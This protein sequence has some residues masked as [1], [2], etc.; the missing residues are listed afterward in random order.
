MSAKKQRYFD[1]ITKNG[2]GRKVCTGLAAA[3]LATALTAS[4][5]EAEAQDSVPFGEASIFVGYTWGAG[6]GVNW[7]IE[8]RAGADFRDQWAC[9]AEPAFSAAAV[10]RFSFVDLRPQFHVSGQAG[11][12]MSM[13]SWMGDV[14][15]GYRWGEDGGFS[16]PLGFELQVFVAQTYVRADPVLGNISTGGGLFLPPRDGELGCAVAGRALH[17]EVGHAALPGVE[18]LDEERLPNDMDPE[19]ARI[20]AAQWEQRAK[21]EWASVP[22]FL[23]LAEQLR[24]AGA[25]Q[26]LIAR[27]HHA[28]EDELRHAVAT[29][30]AAV[31]YSG[32]PINLGQVT[33]ATRAPARGRD[34]LVRLAAESWVDGCL[35]E[36]KAAAAAA[37]EARLAET[38]KLRELQTMIAVDEARHADLAWDVLAWT[39]R[40]GGDDVRHA[41]SAVR[42]ATPMESTGSDEGLDLGEHGLLPESTH[43]RIGAELQSRA[44][45]R[46]DALI[47]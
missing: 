10:A 29:A 14:G 25:P 38:P 9:T 26:R 44:L 17:D 5:A 4:P 32:A 35:G 12:V 6:G 39:V 40:E 36:G 28:A 47:G 16:V 37:Q 31:V 19:L 22:A 13:L 3:G 1:I 33:P 11:V 46:F 20:L 7:G 30:R 24:I 34:A 45:P 23:Q 27:A 21:A 43:R 2:I 8:G 15:L 18:R 42:E 41:M